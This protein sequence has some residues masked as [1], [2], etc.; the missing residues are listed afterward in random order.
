[1]TVVETWCS[2][3]AVLVTHT[4]GP[5][6]WIQNILKE[7]QE[8]RWNVQTLCDCIQE[9]SKN[10]PISFIG[11]CCN[12]EVGSSESVPASLDE[13]TGPNTDGFNSMNYQGVLRCEIVR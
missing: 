4:G 7:E 8:L 6:Y 3:L 10:S 1:M 5:A 13:I 12:D 11:L 2:S 9:E